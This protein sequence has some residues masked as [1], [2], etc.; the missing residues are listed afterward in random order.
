MK[1]ASFSSL[2]NEQARELL[3]GLRQSYAAYCEKNLR[4]DM[5][6]G[7]P[8]PEQLDLS[9]DMF[10]IRMDNFKDSA[11]FDVRNY[12][13]LTGIVDMKKIFAR[14]LDV[15]DAS[16]VV[17]G[18]S[19]LNLMYDVIALAMNFGL[20]RSPRP[21]SRCEKI[22]FLCPSPGY[23]RH[24][25]VTEHFGFELVC[26]PML[27]TGPDMDVVEALVREDES[28][29]G[30]WCVPVFSNPSGA[31]YSDETVRRLATMKTAAPD[32]LIM[33]DNAYCV[34]LLYDALPE[35]LS[36]YNE[37]V[38]AGNPDRVFQF[39]STSK[40]TFAGAGVACLSASEDNLKAYL[41]TLSVQT[42][43]YDKVNQLFHA[44]YLK[45]YVHLLEHMKKHAA[46]LR[47]KFEIVDRVLTEQLA[48]LDIAR[49]TR[50]QGGYFV[51]FV[52]PKGAARR[53]VELCGKAGVKLTEAGAA[54]P[55]GLD[56]DD[57]HIRIAPSYPSEPELQ[58]ACELLCLCTKI[59]ALEL[60]L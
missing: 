6:R 30:I 19:S 58:T 4:L 5:S 51:D 11:G 9:A 25:R 28:V 44:R 47:P 60:L 33:C 3:A 57:S 17:A 50:P 27:E 54:F 26:V 52:A 48:A 59:A 18:N 45:N 29:K 20:A 14:M 12:G 24:F 55:Y 49:W 37:A 56:P 21:W 42:I 2:S 36:I 41:K 23:D 46:I 7:K 13:E 32:F 8:C 22:K 43:G 38:R 31:V 15:D 1:E 16:I 34:H 39:A 53:I 40:I 10:G 35:T